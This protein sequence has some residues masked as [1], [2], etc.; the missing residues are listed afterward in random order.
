MRIQG[1]LPGAT[2]S[3]PGIGSCTFC[4]KYARSFMACWTVCTRKLCT[5]RSGYGLEF[6]KNRCSSTMVDPFSCCAIRPLSVELVRYEVYPVRK[7][8]T[9]IL[10]HMEGGQ[11]SGIT[12][13][14]P[15][16]STSPGVDR[17]IGPP[18]QGRN[19]TRQHRHGVSKC[20]GTHRARRTR[21]CASTAV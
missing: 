15:D 3:P 4:A 13:G 18:E 12:A 20:M 6:P 5:E 1:A 7:S 19:V 8:E 2:L 14:L 9:E 21:T 17:I 11:T 10:D 16:A